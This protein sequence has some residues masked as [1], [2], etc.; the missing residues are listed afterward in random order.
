IFTFT[1]FRVGVPLIEKHQQGVDVQGVVEKRSASHD[2]VATL[3]HHAIPVLWDG[4]PRTM[5]H[6]AFVIDNHTVILGSYNPT[7]NAFMNNAESMIIIQNQAIAQQFVQEYERIK[8]L[9]SWQ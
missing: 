4:N 6:K 7:Q 3:R 8:A 9:S 2:M 5:H 1:D